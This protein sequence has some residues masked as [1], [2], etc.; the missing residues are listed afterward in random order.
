VIIIPAYN[1]ARSLPAVLRQVRAELPGLEVVVVD[2]GSRDETAALA[3]AAG[4]YVLRHPFNLGYGAALQTGYRFALARGAA[5]AVQ[6]DADGQHLASEV[7]ALLEAVR[8]GD[9]DLVIGSRFLELSDYQMGALR[10]LGREIFCRVARWVGLDL[11]DPTSGF[12]ALN[13]RAMQLFLSD[14]F[15]ADYPDVD[16][17]VLAHRCGLRLRE[18]PVRMAPEARAS[19][20]HSGWKPLYYC[21]KMLLSLWAATAVRSSGSQSGSG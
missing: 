6:M 8:R 5:C 4:A 9:C 11:T 14:W 1:E 3:S 12:Q 2:D 20:L 17:L 15:P 18:Q 21:Y 13:R 7:P 19:S 16:V 10:T